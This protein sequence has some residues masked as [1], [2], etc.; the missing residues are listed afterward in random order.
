MLN[1]NIDDFLEKKRNL[2]DTFKNISKK[3]HDLDMINV[4]NLDSEIDENE[5]SPER[6]QKE[7][8]LLKKS[9]NK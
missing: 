3:T 8:D 1:K 5:Y 6:I 9:F 4:D 2:D 7:I